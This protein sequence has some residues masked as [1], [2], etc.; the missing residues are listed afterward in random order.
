MI[1]TLNILVTCCII[2]YIVHLVYY[3]YNAM[4]GVMKTLKCQT[5]SA[6]S[7]SIGLQS[8]SYKMMQHIISL[9][10]IYFSVV[11]R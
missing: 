7:E 4:H 5:L 3:L 2:L 6:V 9:V 10:A 1:V 11:M 8:I